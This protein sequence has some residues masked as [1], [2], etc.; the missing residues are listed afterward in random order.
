M[1]NVVELQHYGEF[2]ATQETVRELCV[3]NEFIRIE[4]LVAIATFAEH[5]DV[6]R[7]STAPW[8]R[9]ARV[10]TIGEIP[11]GQVARYLQTIFRVRISSIC[12]QRQIEPFVSEAE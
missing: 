8:E 11:C 9:D 2:L 3:P 10:A 5:V 1:Q 12:I 4:R 7:Q 6:G